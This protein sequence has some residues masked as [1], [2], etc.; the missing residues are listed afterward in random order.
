MQFVSTIATLAEAAARKS[1][2]ESTSEFAE[3]QMKAAQAEIQMQ[4]ARVLKIN[5]DNIENKTMTHEEAVQ[6]QKDMM[7]FS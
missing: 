2:A 6:F 4:K 7:V 5:L 1:L 3:A